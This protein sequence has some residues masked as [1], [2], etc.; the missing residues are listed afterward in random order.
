MEARRGRQSPVAGIT[1]CFEP[2][3]GGAGNLTCS[4][5]I[6][7]LFRGQ[8]NSKQTAKEVRAFEEA[9]LEMGDGMNRCRVF[10]ES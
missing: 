5:D 9:G 8:R 3:D 2:S 4:L 7:H 6:S 1:S 10:L